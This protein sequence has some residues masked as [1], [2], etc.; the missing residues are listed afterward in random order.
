MRG[1]SLDPQFDVFYSRAATPVHDVLFS[2]VSSHVRQ[3]L[4]SQVKVALCG[5]DKA[6]FPIKVEDARLGLD[7]EF[8]QIVPGSKDREGRQVKFI[9]AGTYLISA[10]RYFYCAL[11]FSTWG[12]LFS[13]VSTVFVLLL[14]LDPWETR[15]GECCFVKAAPADVAIRNL[16]GL[17]LG[18]HID[19]DPHDNY[20]N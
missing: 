17:L 18:V 20:P 6:A 5:E 3:P 2:N 4:L 1:L 11:T 16:F 15:H 8:C 13:F 14:P 7:R 12:V 10:I 19:R 9:V